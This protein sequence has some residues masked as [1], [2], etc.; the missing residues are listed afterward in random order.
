MILPFV[1]F[2]SF[3]YICS[4]NLKLFYMLRILFVSR[5]YRLEGVASP[6]DV[7]HILPI[8]GALTVY[9]NGKEFTTSIPC[10]HG[11]ICVKSSSADT[12]LRQCRRL[13]SRSVAARASLISNPLIFNFLYEK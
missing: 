3:T 1:D 8:S 2:V 5:S 9:S 10:L 6:G 12:L 4:V 7:K 13:I 11:F